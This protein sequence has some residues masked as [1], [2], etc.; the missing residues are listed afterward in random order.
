M[1][2]EN[3]KPS[4]D[5]PQYSQALMMTEIEK[6]HCCFTINW[7]WMLKSLRVFTLL[8]L[9]IYLPPLAQVVLEVG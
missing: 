9:S 1:Y 3:K 6:S 7:F 5:Y 2:I 4:N 8:S